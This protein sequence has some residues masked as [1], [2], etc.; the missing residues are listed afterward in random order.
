MNKRPYLSLSPQRIV[1]ALLCLVALAGF[2]L[3]PARAQ[4]QLGPYDRSNAS[5]MLDVLKND[6]KNNYYDPSLRGMDLDARFKEA[7]D[8]IKQAQTRDQ[9]IIALAQFMLELNDSHTFFIPP[10]RSAR[11]EYGWVMQM[12]GENCFV[13]AVKPRTDA[14]AK[15]LKPGDAILAVDGYRPSRDNLWKMYYRY[16]AL[17]PTRSIR[18]VVQSPGE[19]QPREIEVMSKIEQGAA[20]TDWGNIFVRWLKEG[21][22]VDHDRFYEAGNDLL[23]WKMPTFVVSESHIDAVMAR[24][25]KYKSLVIDL[26]GNGG[27]YVDSLSRLVSH[28]FDRDINVASL[29]GRKKMKPILAKTRGNDIF[30][31]QLIILV[32][33]ESGS[34]S[35]VLA[36]VVQLE[37]RGTVIGDRSAGAVMTSDHYSHETGV[38]RVLYFGT[39]ITIADMVMSD[40]KSL[41]NV[42][43]T[44]DELLLPKGADLAAKRDPVLARAA[45]LLGIKLDAEKAGTLFPKEWK[46]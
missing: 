35:E 3:A 22:D 17:M 32:D 18:L 27:G 38:G 16:Y 36:R 28:L 12:V 40:G 1:S 7:Q 6:L 19:A 20:V 31:G 4:S 34:A 33:S 44:P 14:E 21:G 9:L 23:V 13:T 41:E 37:K 8:R 5:T 29:K 43:V 26:R 45:E 46:K 42:G 11:I 25:R 15:G 24:A 39:S 10:S 2:S 30:K